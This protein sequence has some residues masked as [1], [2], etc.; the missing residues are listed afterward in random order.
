MTD[1]TSA[2]TSIRQQHG[3]LMDFLSNNDD[4]RQNA[5]NS[6]KASLWAGGGACKCTMSARFCL[7]LFDL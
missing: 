7:V 4:M 1:D 5:K 6:F 3:E 2:S